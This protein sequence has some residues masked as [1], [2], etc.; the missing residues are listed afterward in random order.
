MKIVNKCR[1]DFQYKFGSHNV[2]NTIYSNE[3]V[4]N[5]VCNLL[6]IN[7]SVDKK[8]ANVFEVL[9]Y[10]ITI[11]NISNLT[12]NNIFF[13]EN[14]SIGVRFIYNSVYIDNIQMMDVN[15]NE[16]FKIGTI[17]PKK[18]ITIIFKVVTIPKGK[19]M[20]IITDSNVIYDYIYNLDKNPFRLP[21]NKNSYTKVTNNLFKQLN[22]NYTFKMNCN[23]YHIKRIKDVLTKVNIIG[24]KIVGTPVR[25]TKDYIYKNMYNI[26]I[27]GSVEYTI[28]YDYFNINNKNKIKEGKSISTEGFSSFLLA[29]Y[30]IKYYKI[31]K[32]NSNIEAVSYNLLNT[33]SIFIDVTLLLSL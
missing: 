11:I 31:Q 32:V 16:G 17:Q 13:K 6:K 29:P 24:T 10:R 22:I 7:K 20:D 5:I 19:V 9:N 15:P 21:I 1:I 8:V 26:I 30:G 14:L 3:V 25:S 2:I 23:N 27:L 18:S 33:K 28:I 4:T 12:V